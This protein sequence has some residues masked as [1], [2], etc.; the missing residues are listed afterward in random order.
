MSAVRLIFSAL[1]LLFNL[2]TARA[3]D[4]DLAAVASHLRSVTTMKADFAQTDQAGKTLTG[5]MTIARPGKIRFQYEKGVPI[6]LVAD[7]K[8]L[9]FID[10]SVKQKQRWPIGN[11]PLGILLNPDK[12]LSRYAKITPASD[13]R[14]VVAEVKD[15][16]HPE[17]GVIT[18]AFQR[19]DSAPSGL[20]LIGWVSLDS[21]NNRTV[22]RLSNQRFNE[23]VSGETFKFRD[24]QSAGPRG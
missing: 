9:Y 20:M 22:I 6:L 16:R 14:V 23:P 17:Y 2:P 3:A 21:Q 7:G 24:P 11:S 18:L 15:Q 8:A 19:S 1:I 12:D 4:G 5:V 13:A 10:Y